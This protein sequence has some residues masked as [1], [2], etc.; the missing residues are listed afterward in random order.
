M[1][2]EIERKFLVCGDFR[3]AAS[4]S[5][6]I[7]QGYLNSCPER[8]VRVRIRGEKAFISVKGPEENG[9]IGRFEWEKE[10][11]VQDAAEL[12]GLCEAGIIDKTRYF[13]P[14]GAYLFEV[15]VFHGDNEGLIVAEIE[16]ENGNED[17]PRPGWLGKEVTSDARYY[18]SRLSG[19]PYKDWQSI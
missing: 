1:A 17:F 12:L 7:S 14:E 10:I 18:N 15:D 2:Q 4:G 8:T 3:T 6:R 11:P 16:L 5:V 9:H 13:V 19:H